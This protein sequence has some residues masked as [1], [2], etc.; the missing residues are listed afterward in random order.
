MRMKSFVRVALLAL[1]QAVGADEARPPALMQDVLIPD[2]VARLVELTCTVAA[3]NQS[4]IPAR[5]FTFR[6]TTPPSDLAYQRARTCP[7]AQSVTKPHKNGVGHFVE[8][9][10]PVPA[11]SR[12]THE[13]KSQVLLL[14][15]DY[16]GRR[17]VGK[18]GDTNLAAFLA[19]SKLIEADDPEIMAIAKQILSGTTTDREKARAA[20]Q[21]PASIIRFR[22]Q[23]PAG[24]LHAL[25][26]HSGDCTEFAALFCALCRAGNVPARMTG[27]FNMGSKREL[28]CSEPNHNAAEA[29]ITGWGWV[30]VDPNLGG[31]KFNRRAGFA[32][33]GNAVIVLTQAGTW[34]WSTS[35]PSGKFAAGAERP[36][37][38][39]EVVWKLRVLGEGPSAPMLRQFE[40]S[41]GVPP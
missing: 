13:I 35:L 25:K 7:V 16:T 41:S 23:E 15:V 30:P 20:Y 31:G 22:P 19:P 36:A 6:V 11:A 39:V 3:T 37:I 5:Q 33:T 24:A 12:V 9:Q 10:F 1:L 40:A 8:V 18:P 14:P 4:Q 2:G 27:V 17:V 26:T 34:V 38:K 29:F 32:R 21:Y 28:A